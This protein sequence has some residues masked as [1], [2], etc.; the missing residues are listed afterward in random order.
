MT[1]KQLLVLSLALAA[2]SASA[3]ARAQGSE[4]NYAST[5]WWQGAI[6]YEVYPR[7]FADTDGDGTGDINGITE[8]LDYLADLGVDAIWLTP[9]YPSPQVDFGYD[10]TNYRDVDPLYGNLADFD[11]MVSAAGKLGI[12]VLIDMVFNHTSDQHPWFLESTSSRDNPRSDWYVWRDARPGRQPPNNW[13]SSFGGSSWEWVE[14]RG[15]FYYHRYYVEQPDLNWR[16]PAVRE[17]MYDVLRFWLRRGV[18]GFRLDGISNLYEDVALRDEQ[19]LGGVNALGDPNLSRQ[20]TRGLPETNDAYRALRKVADEFPDTVLVGQVSAA[21][22]EQF[23]LAYGNNDQLHLPIN[24]RLAREEMLSAARFRQHIRDATTALGGNPPLLVIDSHDWRRSWNRYGDGENDLA[25]AKLMATLLLAPRGAALIYYGQELGMENY[26]P[27]RIEDVQD[28]VGRRGWPQNKGR[29]GERTP[30]QWSP[31]RNAGFSDAEK[32]WLPVAPTYTSRNARAETADPD[33]LLNYY[34]D[35]IQLRRQNTALREGDLDL[36]IEEDPN[37]LAWISR[38]PSGE[39]AVVILN[40]SPG[41]QPVELDSAAID[42][43]QTR[44]RTLLS[45]FAATS[46]LV[47]LDDLVI[48]PY[49]ALIGQLE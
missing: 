47:N 48:P 24:T 5:P 37:V 45:S 9:F 18:S 27:R 7:S 31:A 14:E 40:F 3:S 25:I 17:E 41:T 8:H 20:Y 43:A 30:M 12:R 35:L 13:I 29:D 15:Q 44:V 23:V 22:I 32:T 39:S 49:G 28:P 33:S 19:V 38:T 21:T 42:A 46:S 26:D 34:R 11:R 2:F 6:I 1:F 36:L 10:V 16:N 4:S